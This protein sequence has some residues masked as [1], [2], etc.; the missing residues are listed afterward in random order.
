MTSQKPWPRE[1]KG[2]KNKDKIILD[3]CGGTGAWSAPYREYPDIYDVRIITLPETD[4]RT[5]CPP[6]NVYGILAA[7]P[8]TEFAVSGARW[9]K[10]KNPQL[11]DEALDIFDAC[12][13]IIEKYDNLQF[14]ALENPIGRLKKLR[15]Q[16]GEPKLVF[17]PCDY[18]DAYT[19]KTLLWGKF[20]EPK[21]NPVE[22]E[23]IT[24]KGGKRFA[25]NYCRKYTKIVA[26]PKKGTERQEIRSITP[27]GFAKAFYKVNQ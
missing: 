4:V 1:I 16:L 3:L 17:N 6:E 10:N 2:M 20:N 18:G 14:W 25:P 19:K 26:A 22:P 12:M 9:W 13:D 21:K 7:P 23:F 24:Y 15:P 8:C 27:A 11:L 5:Y